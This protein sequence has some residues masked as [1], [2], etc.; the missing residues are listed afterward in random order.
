MILPPTGSAPF[1]LV[2]NETVNCWPV[3]RAAL[4][5]IFTTNDVI[6]EPM[7]PVE[8]ADD[9][10]PFDDKVKPDWEA[11]GGP[12]VRPPKVRVYCWLA[13]S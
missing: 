3:E 10:S 11:A 5:G 4:S 12:I 2:L 13:F 7:A 1:A 6:W 9:V 8:K